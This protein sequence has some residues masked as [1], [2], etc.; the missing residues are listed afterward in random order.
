[1]FRRF[2]LGIFLLVLPLSFVITGC[3]LFCQDERRVVSESPWYE[4]S[5]QN[6]V[7]DAEYGRTDDPANASFRLRVLRYADGIGVEAIARDDRIVTDNCKPGA[8]AVHDDIYGQNACPSWDDDNLECFFDGDDVKS[9][10]KRQAGVSSGGGEYALVAN[11]AA[12]S[13]FSCCP[14]SF[15]Q[16]WQGMARI[17]KYPQGGYTIAYTL[18]FSWECLGWKVPPQENEDIRFGFNIC[19][20]D[21]DDGGRN[22]RALF[23]KGDT[24]F[25]YRDESQFGEIVL[26]GCK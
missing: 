4:V 12:Q 22:D 7:W 23:W 8:I 26:K 11:G 15:G 24:L 2:D 21:D 25:P 19:M 5:P 9:K 14:K 13:D 17:E 3:R 1:M 10:K 20:H 16:K 18:W 6:G